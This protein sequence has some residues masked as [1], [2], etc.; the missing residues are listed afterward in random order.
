MRQFIS[1]R[2]LGLYDPWI[3]I[4]YTESEVMGDYL[5]GFLVDQDFLTALGS[6]SDRALI[7][8]VVA[9]DDEVAKAYV[10]DN[11]RLTDAEMMILANDS[12]LIVRQELA[13][14]KVSPDA[15]HRLRTDRAESVRVLAL[16]NPLT[17]YADFVSS[18]INDKFSVASKR[19]FCSDIR[20]VGNLDVFEFLWG[21]FKGSAPALIDLLNH[22]VRIASPV[23]DSR[24]FGFVNAE[25]VGGNVSNTVRE[26]YAGSNGVALP[27]IL[28]EWKD[29][30][31]RPVINAIARN[32]SAWPSTHEYLVDKH[33]SSGIRISIAMVTEDSG[34]LNKIYHGTKSEEIRYWVRANPKFI[35]K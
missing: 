11:P 34:L 9:S 28:D 25:I 27:E 18:V 7:S 20:A 6:T 2:R 22:A 17:D 29:D 8:A 35:S 15:L 4:R 10:V 12:D 1:V 23:I 14:V 16:C 30:P 21:T 24:I 32:A 26:S 31:C 3:V 33:K 19:A 5:C 13:K